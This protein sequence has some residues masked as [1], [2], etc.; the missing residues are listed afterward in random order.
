MPVAKPRFLSS[1]AKATLVI[2]LAVAVLGF[3]SV[4][5]FLSDPSRVSRVVAEALPELQADVTFQ[6]VKLGWLG[7]IVLD[8]VRV[9]PRTVSKDPLGPANP[10][11]PITIKRI[12][13]SH[14]L[15]AMLLSLGD[16]GRLRIEGLQADVVFDANRESNMKDLF[17]TVA[18][19]SS[20]KNSETA[21]V[22]QTPKRSPLRLKLEVDDARVSVSGPWSAEAWVSDP[23]DVRAALGPSASGDFSEWSIEP[24]Q[25]LKEAQLEPSVA[26]GVLAY[27]A[28]V[29]A[30]ATRTGG[31]FSLRL[32]G[33]TLPVGQPAAGTLSGMLLMHEVDLGP[34][35]MVKNIL[36]ALPGS[37]SLPQSIRIADESTVEFR[38]AQRRIWHKGLEF[39]LPLA[40]QGQRLDVHS[41][42]SV[43][44]D[45]RSIDLKLS[46]PIP[47][48]MPQDRP[49][50]A[51]LAGK[52]FT[53]AI[54]GVL[55]DPKVNL[56]G[57]LQATAGEVITGLVGRLRDGNRPPPAPADR[58]AAS[59]NAGR[60][61]GLDPDTDHGD[62]NS[63]P[64]AAAEKSTTDSVID[65]VG[66]VLDEVVKRR[67]E[68]KAAEAANPSQTPPPRRGR[69]LR[70]LAPDPNASPV[71]APAQP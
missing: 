22:G 41:S 60:D 4:P 65:L 30:D 70:R 17:R 43:G 26:Q 2:V 36:A 33:A 27:I 58:S 24:V 63:T 1:S 56:D 34:G 46:L 14:G 13:C 53:I 29:M 7:P 39:G 8:D 50:L 37:L 68:R 23:I 15:A 67:A 71:D 6:S 31:R 47:A 52:T 54:G 55:G 28:P 25:L 49:L 10:I 48:D 21:T 69:L 45:D 5:W 3:G 57:T 51:S 19:G 11:N 18:A 40:K 32:D 9:V 64:T 59:D 20:K 62:N 42:G 38:L 44:L 35:P 12:E 61:T 66:G 16:L